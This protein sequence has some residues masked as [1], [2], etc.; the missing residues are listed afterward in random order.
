[1]RGPIWSSELA[2]RSLK[3]EKCFQSRTEFRLILVL[4]I[5]FQ[6]SII[7]YR[8]ATIALGEI[9]A[10]HLTGHLPLRVFQNIIRITDMKIF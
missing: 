5:C 9:Y 6:P 8:L 1:M 7:C 4:Q 3:S 2:A 10:Y